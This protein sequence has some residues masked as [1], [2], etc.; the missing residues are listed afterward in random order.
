MPCSVPN[1]SFNGLLTQKGR[2][3]FNPQGRNWGETMKIITSSFAIVLFLAAPVLPQAP[4]KA[5][6]ADDKPRTVAAA[7]SDKHK[8]INACRARYRDCVKLNQIPSFECQYI[9]QDC[10]NHIY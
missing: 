2:T 8:R 7:Q 10:M 4:V 9:Y 1:D 3:E 5:R 6:D